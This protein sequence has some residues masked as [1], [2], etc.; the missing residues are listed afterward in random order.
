[1][2][3]TNCL[4]KISELEQFLRREIPVKKKDEAGAIMEDTG[5]MKQ[6]STTFMS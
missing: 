5:T 1:M 4:W 3:C 6:R 2:Q